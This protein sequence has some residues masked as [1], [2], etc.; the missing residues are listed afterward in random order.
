MS[1]LFLKTISALRIAAGLTS[2]IVPRQIGPLFGVP[3]APEASILARLFGSR[4][5]VLGAYLW[6][7]VSEWDATRRQSQDEGGVRDVLLSRNTTTV[8]GSNAPG[9]SASSIA[10]K[11]DGVPN[12]AGLGQ[13]QGHVVSMSTVRQ[14]NVATALWLGVAC[15]ALDVLSCGVGL[16][17][18]SLSDMAVLELG[19]AAVILTAAGLWQL[20]V[21][22]KTR[23]EAEL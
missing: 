8:Q 9:V 4:D 12:F 16:L 6:K 3:M 21:L 23:R 2:L 22:Q 7:T 19:G 10:A 13:E 11:I 18:G 1:T 15:D 5:L 17:E 20:S 14:N